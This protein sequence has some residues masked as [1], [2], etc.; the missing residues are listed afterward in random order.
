MAAPERKWKRTFP[1]NR[2]GRFKA[3]IGG[4]VEPRERR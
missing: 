4:G 3:T 1:T 2:D